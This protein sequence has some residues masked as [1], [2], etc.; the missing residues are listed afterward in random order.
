MSGEGPRNDCSGNGECADDKRICRR[1]H[2][3]DSWI[4]ALPKSTRQR[5]PALL[6][7]VSVRGKLGLEDDTLVAATS[8]ETTEA[9][10]N[11]HHEVCADD[12]NSNAND[13]LGTILDEFHAR[14]GRLPSLEECDNVR[15]KNAERTIAPGTLRNAISELGNRG[16]SNAKT[17]GV[18]S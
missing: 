6:G 2:V 4:D 15:A 1:E 8:T 16:H 5:Q 9:D 18:D 11:G 12:G 14:M 17:L 10:T 13:T 7:V 3:D